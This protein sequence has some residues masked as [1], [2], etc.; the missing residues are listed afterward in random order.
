M[1][2]YKN[3]Y[4][5]L[6]IW[7]DS[8]H[9]QNEE[10]IDICV[11]GGIDSALLLW[12]VFKELSE[13]KINKNI[14][15]STLWASKSIRDGMPGNLKAANDVIEYVSKLYPNVNYK[16]FVYHIDDDLI[17][18][19]TN[20]KKVEFASKKQEHWDKF[21]NETRICFHEHFDG[22]QPVHMWGQT[23]NPNEEDR[24]KY[25]MNGGRDLIRDP[26]NFD[27]NLSNNYDNHR[28]GYAPL[29]RF[30]KRFL[31]EVYRE[32]NLIELSGLTE[33]CVGLIQ[34]NKGLPCKECWWC[35]EKRWAF[36]YYDHFKKP[37]AI[38]TVLTAKKYSADTVN[39][40]YNAIKSNTDKP[41]DFYCYTDHIGLDEDI[42]IIPLVNKDK[43]LQWYKLD[44]FKKDIV[45]NE[46]IV[47]MDIDVD[48]VGNVD[49]IFNDYTGFVGSHRWWWRWRE[50]K[51][52]DPYALSGTMYKFKN[53]E[54]QYIVDTFEKDIPY[55]EEHFIKNGITSG[56]VNGEQHFVQQML[57]DNKCDKSYFP[58]AKIIKWSD[59]FVT[60]L[61]L[62][63]DFD[64]YTGADYIYKDDWHPDI[65]IVHYAGS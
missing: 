36:G 27:E 8:E 19:Q 57:I 37:L 3:K 56:P 41:F 32:H 18:L 12:M 31:G 15:L 28:W 10:N 54:H 50:D 43:K 38:C 26:E 4:G 20:D 22:D 58:G 33:S 7:N 17:P 23:S 64:K 62:E 61:K 9:F 2:V 47:V 35:K 16:R 29:A 59:D 63:R 45:E 24:I 42:I 44:F 6:D 40:L 60:Q 55:W 46:Y 25:G 13:R 53:G 52:Y 14:L 1:A 11:S 51:E 39:K 21:I 30:T 34:P 48:I 5:E 65:R 49:F